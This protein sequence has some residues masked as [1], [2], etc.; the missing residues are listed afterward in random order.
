MKSPLS[1]S[2]EISVLV[3][4]LG[5]TICGTA[6]ARTDC[7]GTRA[8]LWFHVPK[9][10]LEDLLNREVPEH[11]EGTEAY[12]NLLL[13]GE[14]K[15]WSMNRSA[16]SLATS[17][18]LIHASTSVTGSV[19]FKGRSLIGTDFSAG[20]DFT[21]DVELSLNPRLVGDWRLFPNATASSRVN[22]AKMKILGFEVSVIR[23][24][25]QALDRYL[26][27][28]VKRISARFEKGLFLRKEVGRIWKVMHRID[29][30]PIGQLPGDLPAWIVSRPTRIKATSLRVN[31]E[32]LD[33]GV[34]IFAETNL[35]VGNQPQLTARPLPS[36]EI[37]DDLPDGEIELT[38][39]IYADWKTLDGLIAAHLQ[40][41]VV[42]ES[43]AYR[44]EFIAASLSYNPGESVVASVMTKV[45]PKGWIGWILYYIQRVLSA[46]GLDI[47]YLEIYKDHQIAISV[48]PEVSEDGTRIV[49]K[50]ASLM[51]QSTHL[52]GTLP[53]HYYGL[54][55]ETLPEY[56][57][58]HVVL[59]LNEWLAETE[60]MAQ[61]RVGEFT[62]KLA[63]RGLDLNV[64]IRPV[65]R[66]ASVSVRHDGL[67]ARLCAAADI[68][69][70]IL[71]IGF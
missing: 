58:K 45:E 6:S 43:E 70:K 57:E 42:C 31:D 32:G 21:I 26:A 13:V 48:R 37:D 55:E 4:I 62:G 19:K 40:K 22:E 20:P 63:D 64:E 27:G 11:M 30:V 52:M 67:V 50:D 53:A 51:P 41:L 68:D 23:R 47:G 16:I 17:K 25:Q 7:S 59:D 10:A 33:F 2:V 14:H 54:N 24:F 38:L 1:T 28:M 66:L 71:R 8:V 65:T 35:V 56:V 44:M 12:R 46:I 36:L 61:E 9:D 18:N 34:A 69:A 15:R 5:V 60:E 49:F 3:V 39:P 29:R